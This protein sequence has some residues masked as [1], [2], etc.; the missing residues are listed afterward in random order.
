MFVWFGFGFESWQPG[1]DWATKYAPEAV[2]GERPP[3][4]TAEKIWTYVY[5][6]SVGI[7][8]P[9]LWSVH[10]RNG[11]Y[12]WSVVGTTLI[13]IEAYFSV[14]L[15]VYLNHWYGEF[16]DLIQVALTTPGDVTIE[17]YLAQFFT[18]VPILMVNIAVAV[19]YIFFLQHYLFRWRTA[20]NN[21]YMHYWPKLRKVEGASQR[22][23]EDTKR[24]SQIVE[25]LGVSLI[26][27]VM[28]LIAFLPLLLELSEHVT[29]IPFFG[30]VEGALVY[31]AIL[32]AL[33]GTVILALVG[34]RLPGLEF[35]NQKVEAA[36][37]KDL[38]YGEDDPTAAQPQSV[39]V[40]YEGVR[41]NYFKL[42]FNYLYFNVVRYTY[43]QGSNF[44]PFL[45]LGSTVVAGIITFGVFQQILRA[46]DKVEE[47]LKYLANSWTRIIELLSIRKRL[48]VF[49]AH[50][51]ND[52]LP[53]RAEW[54]TDFG[55]S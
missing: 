50:I 12:R 51:Q 22:V 41:K 46:F 48:V 33:F 10:G 15:S 4:L 24:F 28:T 17:Q 43:I 54:I 1:L 29:E 31:A 16:F 36:Y 52:P 3:F 44:I 5:I 7:L 35:N 39:R 45:L 25:E 55:G 9:L 19:F 30:E 53:P 27:S 38:V 21:Y 8:F 13:I 32:S 11:W 20:M 6:L 14:Q 47:S 23:Q 40:Y 49:E 42:Y 34:I 2:E 37:R 26:Q 18:V